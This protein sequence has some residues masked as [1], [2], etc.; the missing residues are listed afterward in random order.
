MLKCLIKRKCAAG[1]ENAPNKLKNKID[2]ENRL[3]GN[4][5]VVVCIKNKAENRIVTGLLTKLS[6]FLE[7]RCTPIIAT[8]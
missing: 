8:L 6:N 5:E 1:S 4:L 2:T 3:M 7:E